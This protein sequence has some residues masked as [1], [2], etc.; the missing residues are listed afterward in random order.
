MIPVRA[1][2]RETF[3]GAL[4]ATDRVLVTGA[5]GWFGSTIAALLHDSGIPTM[6]VTHRPRAI[7]FGSGEA[8]AV[9]WEWDAVQ[10]FAPTVVFDCAFVLRDYIGD[11]SLPGYVYENTVVTGRLLQLAQLD[12]VATVVSVSSGAAVHPVD[13]ASVGV[14]A[15][16]YGYLKRQAE[17][18]VLALGASLGKRIVVARPWSLSGT[19]VSRPDRY[20]FSNFI[21]Q[22]RTGVI[23]IQSDRPVSRRYVGVDDFFA[24]ALASAGATALELDSGGELFEFGDLADRVIAELDLPARVERPELTGTGEDDY[25]SSDASWSAACAAIGFEPAAIGEQIRFVAA[26]LAR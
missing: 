9:G 8:D 5:G 1:A 7:A 16:P 25:Y 11:M 20:A 3:L 10:R 26:A 22:A 23:T 6:L 13:A 2:A 21:Q 12:S 18:A 14:D 4:D 19:L 17:L 24:V 15:N